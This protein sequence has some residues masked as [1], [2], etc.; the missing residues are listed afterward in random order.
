MPEKRVLFLKF[1]S[2]TI[3]WGG[4]G[5]AVFDKTG[6]NVF[7][8]AQ[9]TRR[10]ESLCAENSETSRIYIRMYKNIGREN[11]TRMSHT[12]VH[13]GRREREDGKKKKKVK[14]YVFISVR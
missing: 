1:L 6:R 4:R 11:N 8:T 3:L 13:S 12:L 14:I 5:P 2:F 7:R 10:R 9:R